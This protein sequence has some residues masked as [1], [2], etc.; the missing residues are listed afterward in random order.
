MRKRLLVAD[1]CPQ[2]QVRNPPAKVPYRNIADLD[3][4]HRR[5]VQPNA[6][7]LVRFP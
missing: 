3:S 4:P 1:F 5:R 2:S 7:T 6:L